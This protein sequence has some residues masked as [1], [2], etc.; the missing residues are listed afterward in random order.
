VT[1]FESSIAVLAVSCNI[2][3]IPG[4]LFARLSQL[5][6]INTGTEPYF[7]LKSI[8]YFS[9]VINTRSQLASFPT[10]IYQKKTQIILNKFIPSSGGEPNIFDSIH[11]DRRICSLKLNLIA[12]AKAK[13]NLSALDGTRKE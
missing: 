5:S 3:S 12:R 11:V 6:K 2:S 8:A 9:N 1:H 7:F 10:K 4:S 13:P